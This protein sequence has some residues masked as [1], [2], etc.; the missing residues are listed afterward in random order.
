MPQ[1]DEGPFLDGDNPLVVIT[2]QNVVVAEPP[3]ELER[4][5]QLV[6]NLTPVLDAGNPDEDEDL[7]RALD[8]NLD[9]LVQEGFGNV[10]APAR[11][12]IYNPPVP[13]ID[14]A[15]LA[16]PEGHDNGGALVVQQPAPET[17]AWRPLFELPGY[18]D[19]GRRGEAIRHMG[20]ELF[21]NIPCFQRME[22]E[23]RHAGRD[24]LGEVQVMANINAQGPS[25]PGQMETMA[26]WIRQNSALVDGA[27]LDFP[28]M[29]PGY[30]PSAILA[31]TE[32]ESFLM[33][34]ETRAMGAPGDSLYI[35]SWRGG[36]QVYVNNP[37][38]RMNLQRLERPNRVEP[39]RAIEA[40]RQIARPAPAAIAPPAA[41]QVQEVALPRPTA[42]VVPLPPAPPAPVAEPVAPRRAIDE[43]MGILFPAP[44]PVVEPVPP[45]PT[46]T[47]APA[48]GVK[49]VRQA[50]SKAPTAVKEPPRLNPIQTLRAA[51]FSSIGTTTGPALKRD[52]PDGGAIIVTGSG[53]PLTLAADFVVTVTDKEKVELEKITV[54]GP[55]SVLDVLERLENPAPGFKLN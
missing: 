33:V 39:R 50:A 4:I 27:T 5:D 49:P 6:E 52:L 7:F 47:P 28:N 44:A 37:D 2:P 29:M 18:S 16:A 35:Y 46:I 24:P 40:P 19:R 36:R 1:E 32:D 8:E 10:P 17:P 15:A 51:G 9:D 54:E 3:T 42:A 12:A 41:P 38:A 13:H 20:R 14:V 11:E 25:T 22:T 45:R 43:V 30:N 26:N 23:C 21:R 53:R 55:Q 31:T 34:E 48:E